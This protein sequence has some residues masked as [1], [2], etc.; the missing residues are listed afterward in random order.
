M[1]HFL[2][3]HDPVVSGNIVADFLYGNGAYLEGLSQA[4]IPNLIN[5]DVNGNVTAQG[6][7]TALGQI[8]ATGNVSGRFF[9]GNGSLLTGVNI[10]QS[11][12]ATDVRGNVIGAYGNVHN[13][14]A[15][16]GNIANIIFS[17]DGNM[18]VNGVANLRG[19]TTIANLVVMGQ[20]DVLGNIS[21]GGGGMYASYFSGSGSGLMNIPS[22]ALASGPLFK[23][24]YGSIEG[25]FANVAE[26]NSTNILS[27]QGNIA[28]VRFS[29][30]GN[31]TAG[32]F[33]GN[34]SQL[35]SVIPNTANIDIRGNIVGN[36]S[37][38]A[39]VIATTGNVANVTLDNGNV[40]IPG[41]ATINAIY[42]NA[43]TNTTNMIQ[44]GGTQATLA[45]TNVFGLGRNASAMRFNTMTTGSFEFYAGGSSVANLSNSGNLVITG[46]DA[47]KGAGTA[48]IAASDKRLKS[49]IILANLDTCLNV[50]RNLDLKRFEWGPE[51]A[52]M[53]R[54][55][56]VLGWIAQEVEVVFPAAIKTHP[57]FGLS[58]AKLLDA[59]QLFI[60]TYGALKR[61]VEIIDALVEKVD[62]LETKVEE[63]SAR[64]K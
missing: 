3:R 60:N 25:N 28:N 54:D 11:V 56:R 10:L 64:V 34:G 24:I 45:S 36:F 46:P 63:L 57:A 42:A 51:V 35:T 15:N 62:T 27:T 31:V 49:N 33:F 2:F 14:L 9:I 22:T 55:K 41:V 17:G 1:S 29:M 58:D 26:V 12:T 39:T 50:V 8:Y 37:N 21:V 53:V 6:N 18:I 5:A 40:K 61:T 4:S 43:P 19:Q 23:D 47:T 16:I 44:L 38:V 13:V 48:W 20:V 32:Y 7:V 30:D 59:D 52:P